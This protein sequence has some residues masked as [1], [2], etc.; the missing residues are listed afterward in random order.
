MQQ[1]AE[2]RSCLSHGN[3]ICPPITFWYCV[4]EV[5][6]VSSKFSNHLVAVLY[7]YFSY[8]L[9]QNPYCWRAVYF[10]TLATLQK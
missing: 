2:C 6:Y 5:V 7:K 9:L 8:K 4:E 1:H 3:S 10:A